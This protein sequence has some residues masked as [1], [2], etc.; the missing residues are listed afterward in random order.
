MTTIN[1]RRRR[2]SQKGLFQHVALAIFVV[3]LAFFATLFILATI[4][5]WAQSKPMPPINTAIT[6]KKVIKVGYP[7]RLLIP[8][9]KVDAVIDYVGIKPDGTMDIK[10]DQDKV[11]WYEF[12]PRPGETGSAVI[13][14]HYGWIGDKGSVFNDLSKLKKGD[15]ISVI[16]ESGN[17]S[18]F[19]VNSSG[20]YD[21]AADTS[22]IFKSTD[23]KSHLNLITCE[24]VWVNSQKTYTNRL[25]IFADKEA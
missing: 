5:V 20:K 6:Q 3:S 18:V 15:K 13:A 7:V 24:G 11:A 21:P 14:G 10:P 12:G 17:S 4:R 19:I 2:H 9:I 23:G 22:A 8:V 16:D 25:V 1:P